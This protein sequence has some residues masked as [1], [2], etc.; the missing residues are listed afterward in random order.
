MC[1]DKLR[2]SQDIRQHRAKEHNMFRNRACKFSPDCF[3]EDECL[4]EHKNSNQSMCPMA[5]NCDNQECLFNENEHR[6]LNRI[7]CR[8][9]DKCNRQGC[10]Y[11]HN[12]LRAQNRIKNKISKL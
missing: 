7:S 6:S 2:I 10:Q 9:Q 1:G 4:Y 12:V 3:D 11:Q 8:F 5:E